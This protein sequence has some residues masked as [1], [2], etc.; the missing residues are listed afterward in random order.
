MKKKDIKELVTKEVSELKK[1]L[2]DLINNLK[3]IQIDQK[4]GK[5]KNTNLYGEV[6]KDIARIKTVIRQKEQTKL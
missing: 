4:V 6:L 3:K 2:S 5:L 1:Q